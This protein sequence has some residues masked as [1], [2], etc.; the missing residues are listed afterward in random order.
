MN[1]INYIA[2]KN[3]IQIGC[4]NRE[5]ILRIFALIDQV[6]QRVDTGRTRLVCIK[7]IL[8]QLFDRIGIEYKFISL[9][10]SKN[11]LKYYVD[12]WKSVYRLIKDDINRP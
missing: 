2:Q 8:K 3:N 12:W 4:Y 10:K 9:T 5:K 6:A 7:F 1:V 11:T